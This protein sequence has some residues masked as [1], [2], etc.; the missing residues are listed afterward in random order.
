MVTKTI[1]I[2][3]QDGE[4]DELNKDLRKTKSNIDKVED[5][6]QKADGGLKKVGENSGAIATLDALTGGAA[7]RIRD[8]AEAS[9]LFSINLKGVQA[10]I[11]ATGIGALV[12][13]LGLIVAY[14]DDIKGAVTGINSELNDQIELQAQITDEAR[15]QLKSYEAGENVLRLQGKTEKEIIELKKER[16]QQVL[17]TTKVELEYQKQQ[18]EG[19]LEAEKNAKTIFY[20]VTEAGNQFFTFIARGMDSLLSNLG[21]DIG[22]EG[23]VGEIRGSVFDSLFGSAESIETRKKEIEELTLAIIGQQDKLAAMELARQGEGS[24]GPDQETAAILPLTGLAGFDSLD[25]TLSAE[26]DA[27]FLAETARTNLEREQSEIRKTI[28]EGEKEAK[29]LALQQVGAI[30]ENLSSIAGK[31][32]EVGKALAVA[33]TL[34]NTFVSA[35]LAYKAGLETG[36]PLGI[37]LGIASSAAA[38]AAGLQNVKKIQQVKVPGGGGGGSIGPTPSAPP[39]FNVVES[40]P[41]NQLNQSLLEQND[42]PVQ[43]FVVEGH[44]TTAQALR[45][46]AIESSSLG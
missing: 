16:I 34:I 5:S 36:G 15:F 32:T 26:F 28:A 30:F 45:R 18:L 7:S 10:A 33:S 43:A 14:W 25:Q 22:L 42:Q 44:V 31:Q 11:A 20:A 21:I 39:A 37:A 29:I 46:N 24:R 19:Q 12:V 40:N 38:V 8:A 4:L 2:N 3:V 6:A 27:I 35:T 17:D 13:S 41:Q 23:K 9:K 1:T